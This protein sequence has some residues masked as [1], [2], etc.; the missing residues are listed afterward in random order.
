MDLLAML[1]IIA[2]IIYGMKDNLYRFK[3]LGSKYLK[4]KTFDKVWGINIQIKKL[5]LENEIGFCQ[6]SMKKWNLN[7]VVKKHSG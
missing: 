2:L 3:I 7:I 1:Y 5:N 6:E 4:F